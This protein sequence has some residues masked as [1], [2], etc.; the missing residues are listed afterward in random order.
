VK[1]KVSVVLLLVISLLLFHSI[2]SSGGLHFGIISAIEK[3]ISDLKEKFGEIERI[4]WKFS[5]GLS[6]Y[7]SSPALSNDESTVYFGTSYKYHYTNAPGGPH[8]LY[9]LDSESGTLIWKYDLG[10]SEVIGSPVVA[11]DGTIYFVSGLRPSYETG[12]QTTTLYSISPNGAPNWIYNGAGGTP[13]IGLDGTVYVGSDLSRDSLYAI[14]SD[15]TLKWSFPT[16][17]GDA[18][19]PVIGPDNTIYFTDGG[20]LYAINPDGNEKWQCNIEGAGSSLSIN[21]NSSTI[22]VGTE[23]GVLYAVSSGGIVKWSFDAASGEDRMIRSSP[24]IA[25]DGTIYF[26]TKVLPGTQVRFFALNPNGTLKWIFE[27]HDRGINDEGNDI[28]SSP[29]VGSDGTVYFGCETTYIY[30][31]NPDGSLR[32]KCKTSRDIT[33]PSPAIKSDGTIFIGNMGGDFYAIKSNSF[34]LNLDTPWPKYRQNNQNTGSIAK[35]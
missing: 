2:Q 24:A 14:N 29:A 10:S 11:Q 17:Y 5:T 15:G 8:G 23:K 4:Q 26:G 31:L 1:R 25:P 20:L 18:N 7:Y 22:Y 9:A 30:V 33:W 13:A 34:G 3:K 12:Y 6:V 19:S 16:A 27:P 21:P 28:Y 32:W 35:K